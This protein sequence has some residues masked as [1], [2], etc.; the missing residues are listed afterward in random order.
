MAEEQN[1]DQEQIDNLKEK[2]INQIKDNA[3]FSQEQKDQFIQKIQSLDNEGFI[4]FLKKQGIIKDQDSEQSIEPTSSNQ[5]KQGEGQQ[6]IFCSIVFGDVPS[7]KIAENE[8]ALAV[9]EINPVSKGH[10][11]VIPKEHISDQSQIPEEAKTLAVEVSKK[12]KTELEPKEVKFEGKQ[13]FGHQVLNIIPL[14][15]GQDPSQ[16]QQKQASKEEL[17]ELEGKLKSEKPEAPPEKQSGS[18]EDK[19]DSESSETQ[20][21]EKEQ[22]NEKDFWLPK[23]KP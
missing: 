9:L 6:C 8:K 21:E 18:A 7:R 3:N 16:L 4:Q 10:S 1:I 23:R 20:E 15:E 19:S 11:L 13:M 17:D 22:I 2:L 12:I 5:E 14:Y